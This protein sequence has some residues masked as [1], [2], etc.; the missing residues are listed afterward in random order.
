[1]AESKTVTK[2]TVTTQTKSVESKPMA[3]QTVTKQPPTQSEQTKSEQVKRLQ[4]KLLDFAANTVSIAQHSPEWYNIRAT[5]IG[6]SEIGTLIKKNPFAS[7]QSL[8]S[9][10]IGLSSFTGNIA[11]RWGSM[12]ED[13]TREWSQIVLAMPF[14]VVE[15][16]SVEGPIK[17]QRYSPD[18]LGVVRLLNSDN[19]YTWYYILFEYKSP[20]RAV[21]NGRIAPQY[22]PQVQTGL[23]SLP[24]ADCGIYVAN[25]YRKCKL[26]DLNW[27]LEYDKCF[28]DGDEKKRISKQLTKKQRIEKV[29]AV[30]I[31]YFYRLRTLKITDYSAQNIELLSRVT[32]FGS[33]PSGLLDRAMELESRG[34]MLVEHSRL[35][36]NY[37]SVCDMEYIRTHKIKQ[38]EDSDDPAELV[39]DYKK[40]ITE[41]DKKYI[42]VGYMPWK[43]IKSDICH[44]DRDD[45]WQA[46]VEPHVISTLEKLDTILAHSDPMQ[47]RAEY[48]LMFNVDTGIKMS[49]LTLCDHI[50]MGDDG[51]DGSVEL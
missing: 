50:D 15:T 17:R 39:D 22:I 29:Y 13:R 12:M 27:D 8:I 37:E 3:K 5:T 31:V 33:A 30:G 36:P 21:P 1:M 2:Q 6:G 38:P 16:G 51:G 43:L 34:D 46:H 24:I 32:D 23:M 40:W 20:L 11:T 45:G 47:R 9:D 25:M 42:P 28:H 7:V 44:V 14:S 19:K 48:D 35:I 4:N 10:K 26:E 49:D 18:G 41:L